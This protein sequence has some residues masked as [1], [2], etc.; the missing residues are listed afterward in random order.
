MNPPAKQHAS[1]MYVG[2]ALT[3]EQ[4]VANLRILGD[5]NLVRNMRIGSALVAIAGLAWFWFS[6]YETE[7]VFALFF[8]GCGALI[9]LAISWGGPGFRHAAAAT[10]KGRR[11]P[12]TIVLEPGMDDEERQGGMHGILCPASP[13]LPRWRM[14]FVKADGWQPP[15]GELHVEAAY[16][17]DIDWP[18]L[19]LHS[20]GLLVPRG[21]PRRVE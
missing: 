19:V 7:K 18:V 12:A 14:S 1:G 15:E 6:D 4:Q 10:H 17:S 21:K 5:G 8:G 13:H 20:D 16:L 11:L 2:E 3:L 9:F